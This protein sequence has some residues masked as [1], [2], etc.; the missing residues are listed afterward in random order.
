M[1]EIL[2]IA[3]NRLEYTKKAIQ[4][5]LDQTYQDFKL[6]IWNNGS[7]DDTEYYLE[8]LTDK[9]L[10][11]I[12][13]PTND[14]LASVINR[15]FLASTAELVGKVDNDTLVPKDWLARLVEAHRAYHWGFIGG[16]HFRKEDLKKTP[17]LTEQNKVEVWQK[18]YIGGCAFLIRKEDFNKP[19]GIKGEDKRMFMGLSDYQIEFDKRVLTNGYLWSPILWVDHMEDTRSVHFIGDEEYQ[20][21]K[22]KMRGMSLEQNT[23][24]NYKK[25]DVYLSSNTK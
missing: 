5:L 13:N 3:H 8:T 17:I 4:G 14:T 6:T 11:I 7:T 2:L 24:D 20:D 21:Y 19:I 16:F 25:A 18:P 22:L 15:V 10:N 12:H 23:E 1:I 9:R